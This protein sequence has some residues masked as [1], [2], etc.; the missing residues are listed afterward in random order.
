MAAVVEAVATPTMV[1]RLWAEKRY[2]LR[3]SEVFTVIMAW[4]VGRMRAQPAPFNT[5]AIR[6]IQR[7]SAMANIAIAT[8]PSMIE[9]TRVTR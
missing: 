7:C 2:F 3:T 9:K 6:I 4:K 1:T 8:V 5:W